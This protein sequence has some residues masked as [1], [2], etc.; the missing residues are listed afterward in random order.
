M[1]KQNKKKYGFGTS[2]ETVNFFYHFLMQK[3]PKICSAS[4]FFFLK[5]NEKLNN[6]MHISLLYIECNL[7][8]WNAF[9]WSY[10]T[11]QTKL[12]N[13][14][15]FRNLRLETYFS[16]FHVLLVVFF[17]LY[18]SEKMC[19]VCFLTKVCLNFS[20]FILVWKVHFFLLYLII[21]YTYFLM[22]W[23]D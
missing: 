23:K 17:V 13:C 14:C 1:N 9:M 12:R 7:C 20:F 3:F 8:F 4:N 15:Y 6:F 2:C 5:R 18:I 11:Q 21:I 10:N 19:F 22:C 16:I